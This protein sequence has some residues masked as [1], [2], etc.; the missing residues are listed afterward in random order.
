[1][2]MLNPMSAEIVWPRRALSPTGMGGMLED[3]D[4]MADDFFRLS[5]LST[6]NFNP[7]CDVSES[8]DNYLITFDVPGVKKE[9]IKIEVHDSKLVIS[10]ERQ[11]EF[12]EQ[13]GG[14]TLRHERFYGKFERSFILPSTVAAEKIEA[15]YENGV[16]NVA[17]PKAEAIKSRTIEIQTVQGG[18]FNKLLN[19]KKEQ[20]KEVKVT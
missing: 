10:G 7:S 6:E 15:H 12:S 13:D 11:R 19:P 17:I 2:R 3:F 16:L 20:N 1:M 14:N 5:S 8:K 9:D 4:R 18:F